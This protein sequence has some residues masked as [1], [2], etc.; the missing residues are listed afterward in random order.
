MREGFD[1]EDSSKRPKNPK[2]LEDQYAR[3]EFQSV[4]YW[5]VTEK[6]DGTNIR[7]S[8]KRAG[9]D[10]GTSAVSIGGRTNNAQI[11]CNLLSRLNKTFTLAVFEKQFPEANYV[12]LFGEGYGP[13]IQSGSYYRED[14]SFILFDIFC[15]GWWL[16]P[17]AVEKVALEMGIESVPI[18]QCYPGNY[19][20][21]VDHV[22]RYVKEKPRS[23]LAKEDHEM[24][25]V[26][27]TSYPLMLFRNGEPIKFKLKAKDF[28]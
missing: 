8:Y 7:I 12:V 15:G 10:D 25:G 28:S 17:S 24:E 1:E 6:I 14:V 27:A 2:I 3:E 23:F 9:I 11:P 5:N 16:G 4:Q 20:W 18:L 19:L 13:K 21:E 26:I 22:V